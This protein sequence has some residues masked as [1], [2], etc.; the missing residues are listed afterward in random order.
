MRGSRLGGFP[1]G[2]IRA[3]RYLRGVVVQS[4]ENPSKPRNQIV[5]ELFGPIPDSIRFG[6][7]PRRRSFDVSNLALSARFSEI[8]TWTSTSTQDN[9]NSEFGTFDFGTCNIRFG[10]ILRFLE[11]FNNLMYVFRKSEL[12]LL[13][14]GLSKK[15]LQTLFLDS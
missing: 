2:D 8:P 11:V 15:C 5:F 6:S 4:A 12:S 3:N 9:Q 7:I 10:I 14:F 13:D 1:L